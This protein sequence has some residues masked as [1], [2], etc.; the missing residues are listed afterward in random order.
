MT[1]KAR[2]LQS[3]VFE[4]EAQQIQTRLEKLDSQMSRL[5]RTAVNLIHAPQSITA[6]KPKEQIPEISVFNLF[7]TKKTLD[8]YHQG[9]VSID[10]L[11]L[12][13][14]LALSYNRL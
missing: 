2:E 5:G 11:P 4:E 9:I 8:L 3:S 6:G 10:D 13:Y 12:I 1:E 14:S 7:S